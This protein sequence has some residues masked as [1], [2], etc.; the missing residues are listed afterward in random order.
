MRQAGQ[1]LASCGDLATPDQAASLAAVCCAL[2]S[3]QVA[4]LLSLASTS[5][6]CCPPA[7]A[8]AMVRAAHTA[9]DSVIGDK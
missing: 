9:V 6:S 3:L 1:L 4:R 2:N 7:L 5:S 8:S